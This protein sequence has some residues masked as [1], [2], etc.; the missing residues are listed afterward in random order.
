MMNSS[1][2]KAELADLKR[3]RSKRGYFLLRWRDP[4]L[5]FLL[6][7]RNAEAARDRRGEN[8]YRAGQY[9]FHRLRYEFV[10]QRTGVHIPLGCFDTGLSIAHLSSIVVNGGATIGRNCR[11]HQGVT[12]GAVRGS[13]PT[14]GDNVFI[15]PNAII[16]G[17]V[18]VGDGSHVSAGVVVTKSIPPNAIAYPTRP[19]IGEGRARSWRDHA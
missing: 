8:W 18:N 13:S 17:P 12:I 3:Q 2:V 9:A 14:I 11:I 5:H 16:L 19:E 1:E 15:G 4:V 10:S 6:A 7:L